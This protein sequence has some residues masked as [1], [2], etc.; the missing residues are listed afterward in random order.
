[1]I[2]ACFARA[3]RRC[4]SRP[5]MHFLLMFHEVRQISKTR[6]QLRTMHGFVLSR[7]PVFSLLTHPHIASRERHLVTMVHKLTMPPDSLLQEMGCM[8]A[9]V[10]S[11]GCVPT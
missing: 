7:T 2:T 1:M 3:P 5:Y 4:M 10:N 6:N 8:C 11:H 9:T